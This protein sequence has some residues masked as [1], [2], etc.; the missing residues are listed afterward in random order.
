ME[1]KDVDEQ[2]KKEIDAI[3]E[4]IENIRKIFQI[5]K[6]KISE[7]SKNPQKDFFKK[8]KNEVIE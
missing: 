5:K 6:S 3:A 2:I 1:E 7:S 8:K 4:R